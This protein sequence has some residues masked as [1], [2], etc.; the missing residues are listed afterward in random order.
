ME[1]YTLMTFQEKGLFMRFLKRV[2]VSEVYYAH[3]ST[4]VRRKLRNLPWQ[5][6]LRFGLLKINMQTFFLR[7]PKIPKTG[8]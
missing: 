8:N 6:S 2:S 7:H 1:N 3:K 4:V 5:V